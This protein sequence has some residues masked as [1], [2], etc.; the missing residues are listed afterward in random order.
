MNSPLTR[1][2]I[3]WFIAVLLLF[4][5]IVGV[6]FA[7][8]GLRSFRR[9]TE[10][11]LLERATAIAQALDL[12]ATQDAP[13]DRRMGMGG[14][15]G[16]HRMALRFIDDIAQSD[17]WLL[18]EQA[19]SIEVGHGKRTVT[20]A[21]LSEEGKKIVQE[22]FQG[23]ESLSRSFSSLLGDASITAAVPVHNAQGDVTAALLLHERLSVGDAFLLDAGKAFAAA[24]GIAVAL[25]SGLGIV[26]ARRFLQPL[27]RIGETTR[28]LTQGDYAARTHLT[29]DDEIGDLANDLDALAVRLE[30]SRER[31][32]TAEATRRD[33]SAK[34]SH[35]L[36]TPV[37]VLRSSLEA[38]KDGIVQDP[39][40]IRAYHETLYEESR[41]LE[42]LIGDMLDLTA[43][44]NPHFPLDMA[45]LNLFAVVS[46]AV[47]SQRHAAAQKNVTFRISGPD[48][49]PFVGDYGRLRQMFVT[50]LHNAVKYADAGSV[51]RIDLSAASEE[52]YVRIVNVGPPIPPEAL[53]R[54]FEAFHQTE[55]SQE[56]FGLG[57][58]IAKEIA[59]RHGLRLSAT[60]TVE[61]GT[62][63]SFHLPPQTPALS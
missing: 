9:A 39:D 11:R 16:E 15:M 13:T 7:Q 61:D 4:S 8:L 35:E 32:R 43:L 41:Q 17:V 56:G 18:D 45:P 25:V 34:L 31:D 36:R 48:Q 51:I 5:L 50:I 58:A 29:R 2:L 27:V 47:R 38:L 54:I 62:A 28:T 37:T 52:S 22:V 53:R 23:K 3:R 33:F 14:R 24:L 63:F 6:V 26:F 55:A 20:Y 19:R 40:T 46:D 59:Q 12:S 60:S 30:E 1:K 44:Q 57:L 49:M 10:A 42:R 21:E